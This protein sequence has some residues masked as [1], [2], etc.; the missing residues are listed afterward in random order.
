MTPIEKRKAEL[1]EYIEAWKNSSFVPKEEWQFSDHSNDLDC[2][3]CGEEVES[4]GF[5]VKSSDEYQA[6]D[7][8]LYGMQSICE[9]QAIAICK[10]ANESARIA[11]QL[12]ECIVFIEMLQCEYY[13]S[14]DGKMQRHFDDCKRC[15]ILNKI[16]GEK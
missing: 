15:K 7:L 6:V 11:E 14:I 16:A 5:I 12:L 13:Y 9:P 4:S 8:H 10:A 2:P 1:R 3:N